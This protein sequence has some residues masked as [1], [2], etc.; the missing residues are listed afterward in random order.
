MGYSIPMGEFELIE[1]L[2]P[3]L[4]TQEGV[5]L[6]AGDDAAVVAVGGGEVC[7]TVDVLVDGVHFDRAV[8]TPEDIGWK[9]VAVN[10]SDIAAMGGQ[11]RAAVCGLCR[12]AEVG[13]ADIERLY[14]GMAEA[15]ERWGVSLVGGDTVAGPVLVLSV[16]LLG[17]VGPGGAVLR[18]GARPGDR[19]VVVGWLGAAAA[20]L[21][22]LG[23][24]ATPDPRL[25]AAHRRPQALPAAGRRLGSAGATALID[26]SDGLGADVGRICAA[27]GVRA[28]LDAAVLP[29]APGVAD[30]AARHGLDPLALAY[31][32][33]EDFAL[34]AAL[35]PEVA[36]EAA[37]AAGLAEGVPG[38]V[39]GEFLGPRDGAPL[40][41]L[42]LADGT[43]VDIST[44][45]YDHYDREAPA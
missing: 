27:S 42:A 22:Q 24:E 33:G 34:V 1:R 30:T 26:V 28:T 45:G 18:S 44:A 20:A 4:S 8:S 38:I 37:T 36:H 29:V 17:D 19:L 16:T 23:A 7:V 6:A 32:G 40:V 2:L 11:P 5:P 13:Q 41:T 25:L 43:E 35:P 10:V 9:A 3:L 21:A 14:R 12:P 39:A 31:G 15:C